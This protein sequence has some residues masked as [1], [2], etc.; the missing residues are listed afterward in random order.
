MPLI[1][2]GASQHWFGLGWV[3]QHRG[4]A[5]SGPTNSFALGVFKPEGISQQEETKQR[6]GGLLGQACPNDRGLALP[7]N[8]LRNHT[9]AKLSSATVSKA[10]SS[11]TGFKGV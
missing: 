4:G 9:A 1:K 8:E 2:N 5:G 11:C 10:L 7:L 6:A 3:W